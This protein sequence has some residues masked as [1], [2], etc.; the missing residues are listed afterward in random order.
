MKRGYETADA[1]EYELL[2]KFAK[3]NRRYCT[4][5]E[6]IL[7]NMISAKQLGV[8]FRRQHIIGC[9]IVDFVCLKCRLIIEVDGKYHFTQEQK[10]KDEERTSFLESYGFSVIRF[11]NDKIIGDPQGVLEEI[12]KHLTT[13]I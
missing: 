5:A 9:F 6:N 10:V 13:K 7:W 11:T 4:E 1:F 2:E 8:K 12:Q 3:D